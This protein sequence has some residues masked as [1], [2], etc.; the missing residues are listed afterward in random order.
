MADGFRKLLTASGIQVL[1]RNEVGQPG[2]V[3]WTEAGDIDKYGHEYG[4]R[5][6][7][8]VE[9]EVAALAARC[10][11]LLQAG[12]ERVQ[13]VTDH[14]WILLPGGMPKVELPE[15]LTD[16]R[17]GRC[18][19]LKDS[20]ASVGL[21]GAWHWDSSVRIALAPGISCFEANR[22]YE[23]GGLSPQECIT[24]VVKVVTKRNAPGPASIGELRWIQLRC[25]ASAV[26]A[27][28]GST[29]DI[30][31]KA[32][33]PSTSMVVEAR[34]LAPDGGI[35]LLAASDEWLGRPAFLVLLA[36]DGVVLAQVAT[37]VG[38]DN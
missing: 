23:H 19:R 4:W 21:I 14:G 7:S 1:A 20:S 11:Q 35:S 16:V 12:W 15:H 33:D 32:N 38:G 28:E 34:P 26:G 29:S 8:Q 36:P 17:K 10:E 27:P 6:C 18:A 5:L 2:G 9:G 37:T 24:P 22:E 3:A 13:V 25:R 30:R 31:R